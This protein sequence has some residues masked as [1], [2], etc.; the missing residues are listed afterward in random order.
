MTQQE[1]EN[2]SASR[3]GA[4][5]SHD[6]WSWS[7]SEWFS[8]MYGDPKASSLG[9]ISSGLGEWVTTCGIYPHSVMTYVFVHMMDRAMDTSPPNG[10][11]SRSPELAFSLKPIWF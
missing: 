5:V 6:K 10:L 1:K 9:L 4:R 11:N 7:S 2:K 3:W 8:T